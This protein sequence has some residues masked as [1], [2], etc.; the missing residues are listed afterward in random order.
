MRFTGRLDA[1]VQNEWYGRAR[2]FFSL[3]RSDSVSVSLLEAMAQG[4]IPVVSDLPA[5]RELVQHAQNGWICSD[6][7]LPTASDL[8]ALLARKDA[9]SAANREWVMTHAMF[10]DAVERFVARLYAFE[11]P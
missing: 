8:E 7:Q 9:I 6:G 4:A 1:A 2:W 11:K 5:N 10:G 3:P